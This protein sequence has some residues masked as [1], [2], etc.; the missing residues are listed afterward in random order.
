MPMKQ[1]F[2]YRIAVNENF[3]RITSAEINVLKPQGFKFASKKDTLFALVG[4]NQIIV[5]L[6]QGSAS[7][8][9]K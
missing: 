3:A 5:Y 2:D 9:E 8:E 4:L 7:D 6:Y 1:Q